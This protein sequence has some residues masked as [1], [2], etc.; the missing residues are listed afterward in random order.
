MSQ[1]SHSSSE[2]RLD[3]IPTDW[4]LFELA[5]DESN[6]AQQQA[7]KQLLEPYLRPA[8]KYLLSATHDADEA[9]DILGEFSLRF[10]RGH[11]RNAN[12]SKSELGMLIKVSVIRMVAEFR[13]RQMANEH[14]MPLVSLSDDMPIEAPDRRLDP[15]RAAAFHAIIETAFE[16]LR[17]F[18]DEH[19]ASLR[20]T[21][22]TLRQCYPDDQLGSVLSALLE[23]PLSANAVRMLLHHARK[24]FAQAIWRGARQATDCANTDEAVEFLKELGIGDHVRRLLELE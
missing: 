15:I 20:F 5:H 1:H 8:W 2:P 22:L 16:E 7:R 9:G 18:E 23:R 10:M 12:P 3:E 19:P 6:A 17:R 24:H 21:V 13:R 4:A 14:A 11:F